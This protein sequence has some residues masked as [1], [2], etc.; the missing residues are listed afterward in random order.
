[1]RNVVE[2]EDIEQMRLRAGIDDVELRSEIRGLHVGDVVKLTFLTGTT[3]FETL[4]VRIT[5]ISGSAFRGKL[6]DSP[7]TPALSTLRV[8]SPVAFDAAHIHS[9]MKRRQGPPPS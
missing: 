2:I 7:A 5:S 3:T 9:L 8:G 1:M 4:P 6:A